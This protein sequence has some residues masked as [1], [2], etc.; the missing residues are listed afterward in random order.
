MERWIEYFQT[1]KPPRSLLL[2]SS[3]EVKEAREEMTERLEQADPELFNDPEEF[4]RVTVTACVRI[5]GEPDVVAKQC[6]VAALMGLL[7]WSLE[8]VPDLLFDPCRTNEERVCIMAA[9]EWMRKCLSFEGVRQ[10][11]FNMN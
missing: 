9:L 6:R 7:G 1:G 5:T 11:P 2:K 3:R 10:E 4:I 8:H